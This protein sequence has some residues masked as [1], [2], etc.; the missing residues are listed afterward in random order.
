[1]NV[2]TD[3]Q[4]WLKEFA[5]RLMKWRPCLGDVSIVTSELDMAKELLAEA[6][7]HDKAIKYLT[8]NADFAVEYSRQCERKP[9][10]D[11]IVVSIL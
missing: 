9:T 2:V 7:A 10:M 3:K 4:A 8:D 11:A 5:G 1:M 6:H